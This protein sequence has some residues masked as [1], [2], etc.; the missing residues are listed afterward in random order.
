MDFRIS[1]KKPS[2]TDSAGVNNVP[3]IPARGG[4]KARPFFK[5]YDVRSTSNVS[6][7]NIEICQNGRPI[8]WVVLK[9]RLLGS[10]QI[11]VCVGGERGGVVAVS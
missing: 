5:T 2:R 10:A 8:L 9:N 3:A 7:K 6:F 11:D 4:P 1:E